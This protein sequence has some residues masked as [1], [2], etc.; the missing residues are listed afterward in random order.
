MLKINRQVELMRK[1]QKPI[2]SRLNLK[3]SSVGTLK[4]NAHKL[5]FAT[6]P[7]YS[8]CLLDLKFGTIM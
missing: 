6:T 8:E 2:R 1:D 4:W 3:W 5:L 7:N